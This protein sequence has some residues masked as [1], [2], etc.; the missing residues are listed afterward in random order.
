MTLA[1]NLELDDF[2]VVTAESGQA[3]LELLER[4]SFD[5]VLSDVRMPGMNGVEL[6][7]RIREARPDCPVVLMTG[8]A[9]EGLV[10]DAIAEG[11]FTILP[12]PF[13]V[14]DVVEALV[15]A[16]RR[17]IVLVIEGDDQ[18]GPA[19]ARALRASE[20]QEIPGADPMA[21]LTALQERFVDVC[22][23]DLSLPGGRASELMERIR[24]V[25][26][27]II[28]IAVGGHEVP[29]RIREAAAHGSFL[30]MRKPLDPQQLVATIAR[31]RGRKRA[32]SSAV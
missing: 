10:H 28:Q 31:A 20:V 19:A 23:I 29:S 8:F 9:I 1:A 17:P 27:S 14:R 2:E 7:R 12:K 11:V 26:P 5:L 13:D 6:F 22:V 24:S 32:R 25:D 15:S 18:L 4:E 30:C 16:A 3:A 21:A